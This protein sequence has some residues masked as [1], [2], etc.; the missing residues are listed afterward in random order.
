MYGHWYETE[1]RMH[2]YIMDGKIYLVSY[3]ENM[4]DGNTYESMYDFVV[5][6]EL[7]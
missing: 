4:V 7:K 5:E 1:Y 6:L 3:H 2:M